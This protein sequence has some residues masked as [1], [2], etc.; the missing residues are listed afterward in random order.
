M[1]L[2]SILHDTWL[3]KNTVYAQVEYVQIQIHLRNIYM[4]EDIVSE[5]LKKVNGEGWT[6]NN[7]PPAFP[8]NR[9]L[10]E[11]SEKGSV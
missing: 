11:A 7:S 3:W 2:H 1:Q 8:F 5:S 10:S 6:F 9:E 4:Y